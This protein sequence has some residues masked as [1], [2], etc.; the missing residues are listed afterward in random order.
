MNAGEYPSIQA[1]VNAANGR[2][3]YIPAG[4][5]EL[6]G[7]LRLPSGAY[8]YGDGGATVLTMRP[9]TFLR[10]MF[11]VSG[12]SDVT[13]TNLTAQSGSPAD[14]VGF[15]FAGGARNLTVSRLRM[16]S[17]FWGI[18]TG[19]SST[20]GHDYRFTDITAVNCL[21]PMYLA[22]LDGGVF[23]DW[24]IDAVADPSSNQ[25][26]CLYIERNA[27]NLT[28]TRTNFTRGSGYCLHLYGAGNVH[29]LVFN[30]TTVDAREGR[31]S[32]YIDSGYDHIYFNGLH[33]VGQAENNSSAA[34]MRM[35]NPTDIHITGLEAYGYRLI[36]GGSGSVAGVFYGDVVGTDPSLWDTSGLEVR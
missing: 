31:R 9:S 25:T 6:D 10:W 12:L 17:L 28:F 16:D 33:L 11:D 23:A 8:L 7:T 34:L 18:K 19:S 27:Y 5:Y 1:A 32:I 24:D 15:M 20:M 2:R 35:A 14:N 29:D 3:V 36:Y 4:T 13:V 30:D 21:R 22:D 26:H